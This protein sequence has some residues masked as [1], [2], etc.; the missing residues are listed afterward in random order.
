MTM[1]IILT[2]VLVLVETLVHHHP[3]QP[4]PQLVPLPIPVERQ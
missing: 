2:A 3:L 4:K 1:L